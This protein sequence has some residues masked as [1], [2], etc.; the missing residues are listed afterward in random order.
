MYPDADPSIIKQKIKKNVKK[1]LDFYC[2]T[3]FLF[4]TLENDVKVPSKSIMQK[5]FFKISFLLAS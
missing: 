2:L 1:S 5:L 3:F 4:F